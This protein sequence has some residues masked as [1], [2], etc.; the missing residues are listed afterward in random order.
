M[1]CESTARVRNGL[2][3]DTME[4]LVNG[5]SR[6]LARAITVHEFL[7][8]LNLTGREGGIAVC[9]NGEVI[10]RGDW[11]SVHLRNEDQIEIVTAT[12]GG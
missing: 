8:D 9:V 11:P 7:A 5:E 1:R 3:M 4:I 6:N 10:R 12:Q 2:I